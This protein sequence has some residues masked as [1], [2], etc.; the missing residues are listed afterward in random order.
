MQIIF[1]GYLLVRSEHR[2]TS[3]GI[4]L[5]N[6]ISNTSISPNNVTKYAGRNCRPVRCEAVQIRLN[7]IVGQ[8]LWVHKH[9]ENWWI[10]N[11]W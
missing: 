2:L 5:F 3:N 4:N 10:S 11:V 7:R 6:L 1:R 8:R 9:I